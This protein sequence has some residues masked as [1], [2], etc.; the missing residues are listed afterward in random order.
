MMMMLSQRYD[1]NQ[2]WPIQ[3]IILPSQSIRGLM[4]ACRQCVSSGVSSSNDGRGEEESFFY[5]HTSH[6]RS[7]S[8][9]RYIEG[10][11]RQCNA[12]T[13]VGSLY[14]NAD[15]KLQSHYIHPSDKGNKGSSRGLLNEQSANLDAIVTD[16]EQTRRLNAESI[17]K[18]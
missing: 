3:N 8:I 1:F 18:S 6:G 12:V 4:G 16:I 14:H 9:N 17:K 10:F 15:D 11:H 13:H 7:S 2:S 5:L